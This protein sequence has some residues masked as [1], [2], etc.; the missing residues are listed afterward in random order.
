MTTPDLW[1]NLHPLT[2]ILDSGPRV[3]TARHAAWVPFSELPSRTYAL[4][5]S[6][7]E[8]LVADVGPAALQAVSW[9]TSHGRRA[10]LCDGQPGPSPG[11]LWSPN[12]WLSEAP[13]H[14]SQGRALDLGCGTGRD[15]V[16]LASLGWEVTAIDRLPDALDRGRWLDSNYRTAG[17]PIEWIAADLATALP[18]KGPFDLILLFAFLEKRL[19]PLLAN[20]LPPTGRIAIET[21]DEIHREQTGKPNSDQRILTVVEAT[22]LMPTLQILS[23]DEGQ[24]EDR[25]TR[26]I[27]MSHKL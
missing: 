13:L 14:Q 4:C 23:V 5:G 25:H 2:R 7:Q 6:G 27:L 3:R 20:L 26:R 21:L 24:R 9:L 16:A 11:R 10:R 17:P 19:L 12:P 8:I 1:T 18:V 15:A 22:A